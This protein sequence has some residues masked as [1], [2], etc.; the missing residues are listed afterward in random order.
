MELL[1]TVVL[2]SSVQRRESAVFTHISLPAGPPSQPPPRSQVITE[3]QAELPVLHSG[4]PLVICFTHNSVY[5]PIQ[6][7]LFKNQFIIYFAWAGSLFPGGPVDKTLCS[8]YR[9]HSF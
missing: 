5:V 1:Y 2:V 3:H 7:F 8:Q 4:F 9:G 6:H